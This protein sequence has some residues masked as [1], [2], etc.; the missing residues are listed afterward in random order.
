MVISAE[1]FPMINIGC[2]IFILICILIGIKRGFLLQ[3]ANLAG[4]IAS[5]IFAFMFA[6]VLAKQIRLFPSSLI[7]FGYD[8]LNELIYPYINQLAWFVVIVLLIKIVILIL[9]PLIKMVQ[10]LPVLKQCNELFGGILGGV[11]ALLWIMVLSVALRLPFFLNGSEV[12]E[13]TMIRVPALM[14]EIGLEKMPIETEQIEE[15]AKILDNLL[16]ENKD[17]MLSEEEIQK[18]GNVLN[19]EQ[20]EALLKWL[21][22]SKGT[23]E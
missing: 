4:M 13:N 12:V 19:E 18:I 21:N 11:Q 9:K 1:I 15:A 5:L 22:E 16:S 2:L 10:K 17:E 14:I 6:P 7:D 8:F 20:V 3:L 23:D